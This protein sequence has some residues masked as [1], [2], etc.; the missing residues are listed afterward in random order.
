MTKKMDNCVIFNWDDIMANGFK[1][2]IF[3]LDGTLV[4]TLADISIAANTVFA[5]NNLPLHDMT[6]YKKL[7]GWGLK[8]LMKKALPPGLRDQATVNSLTQE[9]IETYHTKP[10]ENSLLYPGISQLLSQ[11]QKKSIPLG[12][13]TNKAQS[14]TKIIVNRLLA[15]WNF[16]AVQGAI[17]ELPAK[18]NPAGAFKIAGYMNIQPKE[19][20]LLGDSEIDIQTALNAGMFPL[21]ALW[22]F[23][24]YNELK[25]CGVKN[26]INRPLE[27]LEYL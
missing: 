22:G 21:A 17:P 8:E 5:R 3:D 25:M 24:S 4:N 19:I 26:F 27:L 14:I 1:A 2:I 16:I 13:L 10:V 6:V 20:I 23:R 12:I 11:L 7:I 15:D 9:L 18:P